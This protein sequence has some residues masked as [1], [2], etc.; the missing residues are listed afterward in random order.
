[1]ALERILVLDD[2]MVIR[3]ALEEQLRRRRYSVVGVATL[4][5]ATRQLE[6]DDF[7]LVFLDVRL[8]DGDGT[9]LL[10]R[11]AAS[12]A[13]PLVV[14]ITGHGSIESAV[15]CMRAG[16]FDYVIKP[17]SINQIDVIL[18]KAESFSQLVKVNQFLNQESVN[19]T[20]LIGGGPAME[21]LRRMILRVAP[22]EATVLVSGENGTGK[23]LVANEIFRSSTRSRQPFIRVNCASISESLIESEFFGHEKGSFTGALQRREGRFELANNGTILLDEISEISLKVQA[24]LLRVLQER[25]FERVGGNKTIKV[26]VR[27]IATTNRELHSLVD[28]GEFRQDLYYRL[29]VFPIHVPPLRERVEDITTL[30]GRFLDRFSRNHG[31]RVKGVQ[32]N[33]LK[34]LMAHNW[35]GNVRE[36]QNT[37]ERAVILTEPG[38]LLDV[39]ALGLLAPR[40]PAA[41]ATVNPRVAAPMSMGAPSAEL[42]VSPT[43]D[44]V[45][46]P[47]VPVVS[48]PAE[49]GQP[50]PLDELEKRHILEV[51][52]QTGGNR[53]Q[54][55]TALGISIRTL[56]N[57]LAAYRKDGA[58]IEGD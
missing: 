15:S 31:I 47:V 24:K 58:V 6:K 20:E 4:A 27:V 3:K 49:T 26:N 53:T 42:P 30:A 45:I 41:P 43:P 16:A 19:A 14:M 5:E 12:A 51:V 18:K 40:A 13:S 57:K 52:R 35:P 23:E 54:A 37:I 46:L 25:E 32:E 10:E 2:E 56:R 29:N 21:A 38:R 55:A 22:T 9:E 34:A 33:A 7:D 50:M 17:F 28:R 8:P 36:L 44:P 48:G 11:L 1:M 39:S